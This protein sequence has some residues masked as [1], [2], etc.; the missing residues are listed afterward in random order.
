MVIFESVQTDDDPAEFVRVFETRRQD[1]AVSLKM[2]NV[3][4][5]QEPRTDGDDWWWCWIHL[6]MVV[7]E[8]DSGEQPA[9]DTAH[10]GILADPDGLPHSVKQVENGFDRDAG[11]DVV[12]GD[13]REAEGSA[14]LGRFRAKRRRR[15][16]SVA[17]DVRIVRLQ[18]ETQNGRHSAAKAVTGDDQFVVRMELKSCPQGAV[19]AQLG[20]K[21]LGR[22]DHP[23][24][25]CPALSATGGQGKGLG[26][27]VQ[28]NVKGRSGSSE[29]DHDGSIGVVVSDAERDLV[30][31][32]AE[33]Q[34]DNVVVFNARH[35]FEGLFGPVGAIGTILQGGNE[36][37]T[38][39]TE[40]LAAEI[41]PAAQPR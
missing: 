3:S 6:L 5:Q 34:V 7:I 37:Q 20:I 24:V 28:Q 19:P 36:P 41:R 10:L 9:D 2:Q 21:S 25:A 11:D 8:S 32:V 40:A 26:G 35:L 39:A 18:E 15:I 27:N 31:V 38:A 30:D 23:F 4:G 13:H 1:W 16:E 14:V 22:L 17:P 33:R 12:A 29:E